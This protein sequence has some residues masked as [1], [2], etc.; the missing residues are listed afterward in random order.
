MEDRTTSSLK[1]RPKRQEGPFKDEDMSDV[2]PAT[3]EFRPC[4]RTLD[5]N[6][7]LALLH[8]GYCAGSDGERDRD[9]AQGKVCSNDLIF[10]DRQSTTR[11]SQAFGP[12]VRPGRLWRGSKPRQK[13]PCGSRGGLANHYA[14]GVLILMRSHQNN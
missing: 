5:N 8:E 10:V 4:R 11:C 14:I 12:S 13:V 3:N 1:K 6:P 7:F 2:T 9:I